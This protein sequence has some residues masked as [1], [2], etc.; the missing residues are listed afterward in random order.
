MSVP[1]YIPRAKHHAV[2]IMPCV[3]ICICHVNYHV[4]NQHREGCHIRSCDTPCHMSW[5][6]HVVSVP[7]VRL[8]NTSCQALCHVLSLYGTM[9]QH[10]CLSHQHYVS[11]QCEWNATSS[12]HVR[13]AWV[14]F[15]VSTVSTPILVVPCINSRKEKKSHIIYT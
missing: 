12:P 13:L 11:D 4:S 2:H 5:Y 15:H 9:C 10:L 7:H 14:E 1:H 8:C 3:I 6:A